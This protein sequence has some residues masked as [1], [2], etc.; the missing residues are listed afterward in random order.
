MFGLHGK[1]Y[2]LNHRKKSLKI[3]QE[4]SGEIQM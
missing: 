3:P 2:L 1:E 4:W